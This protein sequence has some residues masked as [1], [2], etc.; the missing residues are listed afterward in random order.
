MTRS[1]T[2]MA[3]LSGVSAITGLALLIRP[4]AV[5]HLLGF[6]EG[7]GKEQSE[8][9]AYATRIM[10]AMLFALGLFLGS[11]VLALEYSS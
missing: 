9:A 3:A 7:R 11:A 8:G 2:I 10:G 4:L 5:R 6:R 1:L